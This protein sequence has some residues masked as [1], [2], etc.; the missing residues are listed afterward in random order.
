METINRSRRSSTSIAESDISEMENEIIQKS[1]IEISK[2]N[3]PNG[4]KTA[5]DR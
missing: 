5:L 3:S 4:K 2:N 1:G